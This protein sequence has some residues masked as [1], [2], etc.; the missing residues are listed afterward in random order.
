MHICKAWPLDSFIVH[1]VV[2]VCFGC[3]P[4]TILEMR[5]TKNECEKK[6]VVAVLLRCMRYIQLKNEH[7]RDKD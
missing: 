7:Q 2:C 3:L 6:N 1:L 5:H 4:N